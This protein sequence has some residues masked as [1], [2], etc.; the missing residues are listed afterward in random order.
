MNGKDE[1]IENN[2]SYQLKKLHSMIPLSVFKALEVSG[3]LY[4]DIDTFVARAISDALIAEGY[5]SG[6]AS[7]PRKKDVE[8][9]E[10]I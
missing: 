6:S 10:G 2:L 7:K 9:A 5:L 1:N 3:H 4:K 8:E